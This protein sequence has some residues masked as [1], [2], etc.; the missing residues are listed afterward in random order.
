MKKSQELDYKIE[1]RERQLKRVNAMDS[2]AEMAAD[3]FEGQKLKE[4]FD[5]RADEHT[6]EAKKKKE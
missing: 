2:N 5:R 3:M 4:Y 1:E 6:A